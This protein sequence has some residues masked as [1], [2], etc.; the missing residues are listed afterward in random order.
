MKFLRALCVPGL[1]VFGL[2]PT[3]FALDRE[4]FTFTNYHLHVRIEPEQQR[5]AVRGEIK[6]RNDSGVPQ[7]NLV[8][9]ISS[10]LN[11]RSISLGGKAVQFVSQPYT[12]DIDHTGALSEAIVTLPQPVAPYGMVELDVGYEGVIPL[13]T[14][15]LT[16]I[17]VPENRAKHNDWDAISSFF[18][19]LRGVGYVAWYPVA[20]EAAS[21]SDGD[22]VPETI[23]RWK[24]R[25]SEAAMSVEFESTSAGSFFFSGVPD[26]APAT[27]GAA[28]EAFRITRFGIDVPTFVFAN[29]KQ[30]T[31]SKIG[32]LS[33]LPGSEASAKAYADE[34]VKLDAFPPVEQSPRPLQVLQLPGS[35]AQPFVTAGILLT[36]IPAATAA[37]SELT[38]VYAVA[39]NSMQSPRPWIQEGLARYAELRHIGQRQGRQ[40][41]LEYLSKHRDALTAQSK[42]STGPAAHSLI[43]AIDDA[44]LQTKSMDVWSMLSDMLGETALLAALRSYRASEDTEPAYLQRLLEKSSHRDLEW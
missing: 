30:L 6:L 22:S 18:T 26:S 19:A 13:D 34:A 31:V 36:P 32:T 24:Q 40:E 3:S 39:R 15:R 11:W 9:Q 43:N 10:S 28:G 29:Y 41:A 27:D 5:L 25:H 8:L 14:T 35:H 17:G 33:Y 42:E 44:Y 21:L 2:Q 38:L 37:E 20:M 23:G 4:A 16:Q 12:S 7:K 1:I